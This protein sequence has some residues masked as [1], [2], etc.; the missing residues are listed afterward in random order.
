M[1]WDVS[2]GMSIKPLL[3]ISRRSGLIILVRSGNY[4]LILFK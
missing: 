1:K 3:N 4:G 2:A